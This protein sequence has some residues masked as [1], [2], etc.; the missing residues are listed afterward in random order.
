MLSTAPAAAAGALRRAR[1][2][3]GGTGP[4]GQD[5][6]VPAGRAD[7]ALLKR[8]AD[9]F[10]RADAA[11]LAALL[12]DGAELEMP[13]VRTWFAGRD[14]VVSVL[15]GRATGGDGWRVVPTGANGQP[16]LAV[17]RRSGG[18]YRPYG[19]HVLTVAGA[20]V[21]RVTAFDDPALVPAFDRTP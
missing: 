5:T 18:T 13:P 11:A 14:A 19:V 10:A 1:A 16:A 7:R 12:R 3:L 8:Y 20:R 9:A 6:A 15:T 2:L 4:A 21:S 17:H